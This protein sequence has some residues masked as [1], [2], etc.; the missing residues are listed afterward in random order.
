MLIIIRN[1]F[2]FLNT[3]IIY[4]RKS[5]TIW[6]SALTTRPLGLLNPSHCFW[7]TRTNCS[8]L[9]MADILIEGPAAH[10]KSKGQNLLKK[11]FHHASGYK[12]AS[13]QLEECIKLVWKIL[14]QY[15]NGPVTYIE[16]NERHIYFYLHSYWIILVPLS[17]PLIGCIPC[18]VSFI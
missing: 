14:N 11:I 9:D 4:L 7:H 1:K 16:N 18:C 17:S 6:V 10:G 15:Q 8:I 3:S 13:Q 2:F 5:L 12:L